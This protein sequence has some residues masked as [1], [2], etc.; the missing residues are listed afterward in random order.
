MTTTFP[1]GNHTIESHFQPIF[2]DS[3][4]RCS[5]CGAE[6]NVRAHIDKA[7][8]AFALTPKQYEIALLVLKGMPTAEIAQLLDNSPK[9]IKHHIESIFRSVGVS[10][11]AE[12]FSFIFPF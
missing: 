1:I 7:L 12:L 10:S 4:P 9:T 11:R 2:D 5:A 6:F 8:S 3:A